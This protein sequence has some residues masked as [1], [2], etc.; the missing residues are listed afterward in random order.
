M[1]PT[2]AF[3]VSIAWYQ[4]DCSQL[5]TVS[6]MTQ[7]LC[8]NYEFSE[9]L[10]DAVF[11]FF[12]KKGGK[13]EGAKS[14]ADLKGAHICRPEGYSFHD[15]DA[16]GL[17]D[18]VVTISVPPTLSDCFKGVADGTYDIATVESQAAVPVIQELGIGA[19]VVENTRITSIQSI[20]A[21][22][23]KSNPRGRE[24]LTYLNRGLLEMRDSGECV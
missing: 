15:L 7:D 16:E 1:L 11:G 3:D 17:L 8:L 6:E 9:S 14:F 4:P 21:M 13:F 20:A 2:G 5:D 19:D 24:Y 23:W 18:P 10:Y 12:S 22:S